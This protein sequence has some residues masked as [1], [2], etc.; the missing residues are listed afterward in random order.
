M[1]AINSPTVLASDYQKFIINL[2]S[3]ADIFSLSGIYI[4]QN[5]T[6]NNFL[7]NNFS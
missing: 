2:W 4:F 5:Q 3:V 7:R 6:N 1:H